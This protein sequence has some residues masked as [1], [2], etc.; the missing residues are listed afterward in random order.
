MSV[1][2][3][4]RYELGHSYDETWEASDLACPSCA[5]RTV[6]VDAGAGDYYEGPAHLCINCSSTFTMPR[7]EHDPED[8]QTKQRLEAILAHQ[9][10][11]KEPG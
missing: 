10:D 11:G 3:T 1:T 9:H 5:E 6:W 7:L 2:L 8:S 4:V